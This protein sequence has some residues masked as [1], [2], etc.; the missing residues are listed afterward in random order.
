MAE[1]CPFFAKA[2]KDKLLEGAVCKEDG[3][4]A[5]RACPLNTLGL[6]LGRTLGLTI[7]SPFRAGL[8]RGSGAAKREQN[9]FP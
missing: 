6:G 3:G 2:T 8:E 7:R 1:S 9:C 5:A 4:F